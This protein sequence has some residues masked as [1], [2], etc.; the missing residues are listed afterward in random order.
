MT[1]L[2]DLVRAFAALLI[3]DPGNAGRLPFGTG[4]VVLD[5]GNN[6]VRAVSG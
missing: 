1:A 5:D 2:A 4:L 3:P 6:R